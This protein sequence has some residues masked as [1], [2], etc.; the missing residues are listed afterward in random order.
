[1]KLFAIL[2]LYVATKALAHAEDCVEGCPHVV[3]DSRSD[4]LE[5][6]VLHFELLALDEVRDVLSDEHDVART[7]EQDQLSLEGNDLLPIRPFVLRRLLV[8]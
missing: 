5:E 2:V 1:M 8:F 4:H 3:R 6:V 7:L